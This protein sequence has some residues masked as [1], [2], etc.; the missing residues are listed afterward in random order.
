MELGV[1]QADRRAVGL[2]GHLTTEGFEPSRQSHELCASL[3]FAG[4]GSHGGRTLLPQ[5]QSMELH[6][7]RDQGFYRAVIDGVPWKVMSKDVAS[8]L[9]HLS[10]VQRMGNETL[11]RAE[12]ELQFMCRRR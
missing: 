3:L 4:S 5:W 11:Q 1:L 7:K 6:S 9:L 8:P 12:H 10:L 2:S